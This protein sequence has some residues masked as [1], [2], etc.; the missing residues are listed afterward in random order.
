[1][2]SKNLASLPPQQP[3]PVSQMPV[4]VLFLQSQVQAG[5]PSPAEDLGAERINLADLLQTDRH[6]TYF[7][8]A[9]GQSMVDAGIYDQDILVIRRSK[10]PRHGHIVVA[11][12]DGEFTVKQL[13]KKA[14]RIKLQAANPTFPDIVP[15]EGQ[16]I[17]VWGVVTSTIKIFP[18]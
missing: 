2:N 3:V 6:D 11:T 18:E 17:D 9:S 12:V 16:S 13:Y 5:F 8:R 15:K 1:M 10:R 7:M 4:M 14:G